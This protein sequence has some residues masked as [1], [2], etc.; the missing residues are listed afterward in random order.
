MSAERILQI[1]KTSTKKCWRTYSSLKNMLGE[2]LSEAEYCK[3]IKDLTYIL[4]V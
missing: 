3:F 4:N 1:A 2:W